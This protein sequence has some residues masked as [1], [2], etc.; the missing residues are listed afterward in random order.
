MIFLI[1]F[2]YFATVGELDRKVMACILI[3]FLNIVIHIIGILFFAF[4][5]Q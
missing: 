3:V 4:S 5:L 1:S 2:I